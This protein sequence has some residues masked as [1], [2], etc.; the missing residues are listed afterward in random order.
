MPHTI[1]D[2]QKRAAEIQLERQRAERDHIA[3]GLAERNARI[4]TRQQAAALIPQLQRQRADVEAQREVLIRERITPLQTQLSDLF[5]ESTS[6]A[7]KSEEITRAIS[8]AQRRIRECDDV[9]EG[10]ETDLRGCLIESSL[11]RA[12]GTIHR[13]DSSDT[14]IVTDAGSVRVLFTDARAKTAL[15]LHE[16]RLPSSELRAY[17]ERLSRALGF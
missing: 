3:Q 4:E 10:Y 17:R 12:L 13:D 9:L 5:A 2:H 6:L 8:D 14:S 1:I 15:I 16:M 7:A 11:E